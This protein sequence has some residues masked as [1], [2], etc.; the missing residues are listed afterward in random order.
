[1][2][3]Q[4]DAIREGQRAVDLNPVEIDHVEGPKAFSNLALIY[5][6]LGHADRALPMIQSLLQTPGA[7]FFG[8][9]SISLWELRLRWEWDPLRVDPRFQAILTR[10][11]PAT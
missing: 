3:R 1:L 7:V 4:E 2:G 6:R 9:A 8:E 5:A 11:E 10:P